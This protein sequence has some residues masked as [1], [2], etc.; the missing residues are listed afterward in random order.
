[1]F[2]A[3]RAALARGRVN[4]RPAAT[5]PKPGALLHAWPVLRAGKMADRGTGG[6]RAGYS[7]SCSFTWKVSFTVTFQR[8]TLLC[9]TSAAMLVTWAV[10]TPEIVTAA[11]ATAKSTACSIDSVELP[12]SSIVFST[13]GRFPFLGRR[14]YAI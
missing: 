14:G 7:W 12:V 11:R 10:C 5:R 1:M 9:S 3:F 2:Q 8:D 6:A 4:R 13:M